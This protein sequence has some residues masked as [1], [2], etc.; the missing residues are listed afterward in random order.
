MPIGDYVHNPFAFYTTMYHSF[1]RILSSIEANTLLTPTA[2]IIAIERL[3][4]GLFD[5]LKNK[6]I[7]YRS[8]RNPDSLNQPL[9][10]CLFL[11]NLKI[12]INKKRKTKEFILFEIICK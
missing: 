9:I 7:E 1:Y 12:H 4:V 10:S 5:D 3:S 11:K 8:E 6:N 2:H